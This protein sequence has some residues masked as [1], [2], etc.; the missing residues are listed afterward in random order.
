MAGIAQ[1]KLVEYIE[2]YC[3]QGQY[4]S[5][6]KRIGNYSLPRLQYVLIFLKEFILLHR[7]SVFHNC[8]N[9]IEHKSVILDS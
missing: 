6:D 7:T 8:A 5:E 4:I 1:P 3:T 9:L 2:K